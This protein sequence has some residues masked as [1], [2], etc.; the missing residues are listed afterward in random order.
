MFYVKDF[1]IYVYVFFLTYMCI[2][3]YF[4]DD[5]TVIIAIFKYFV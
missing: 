5:S 1:S 2:I 4:S 3:I